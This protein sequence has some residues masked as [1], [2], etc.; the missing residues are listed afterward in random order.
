[1]YAGAKRLVTSLWKVDDDATAQL[2]QGFYREL[3]IEQKPPAAALRAAKL[4]MW[5]Q[6]RWQPPFYWGAFTFQGD[7][8]GVIAIEPSPWRLRS[9]GVVVTVFLLVLTACLYGFRRR[10]KHAATTGEKHKTDTQLP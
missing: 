3:L 2:M 4:A 7:L 5:R 1:M 8:A 9:K 10:K 6:N